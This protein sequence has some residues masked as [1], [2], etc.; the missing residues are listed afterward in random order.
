M[1][2]ELKRLHEHPE[3]SHYCILT[4]NNLIDV[5]SNG[6][7]IYLAER[8]GKKSFITGETQKTE[9]K[10]TWLSKDIIAIEI[11]PDNRTDYLIWERLDGEHSIFQ[12]LSD[13]YK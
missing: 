7:G 6:G 11:N 10:V 9:H 8:N 2:Q 13:L 1:K 12:L 4:L 3:K 5:T